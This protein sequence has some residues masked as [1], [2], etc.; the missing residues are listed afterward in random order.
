M[1]RDKLMN[2]LYRAIPA[3]D[4]CLDA[5]LT[6]DRNLANAP[7][8]MLKEILVSY[9]ESRRQEI[10]SGQCQNVDSL[11]LAA[12]LPAMLSAAYAGLAPRLKKIINATG[13]VVH[14]NLGRS[15][16]AKTAQQAVAVAASGYCN[17]ELDLA[18]GTRGSRHSLVEDLIC[19]LSRAEAAMTVNNNAAAVML[20]L[21]EFC[22]GGE[23]IV[24]RG[25]LVEIGGSFR[26]PAIL[27]KS[28]CK[29]HEVG[30][31]NR[32]H[33]Y[34]YANAINEQT[35]AILRVH[36]SNY[37]IVGFHSAV[38]L[39]ELASL[40]RE[41]HLPLI[42]D[43]GSGSLVDFSEWGLT[44]EPTVPSV[45]E[46]GADIVTFSGDKVLGGP[47]AGIIA[48][49][50]DYV[51]KLKK[52]Q[53]ARA[54]R[55]DKLCLAA[56]EATLRLYLD[57]E[58]AIREIPTLA[59]ICRN[60]EELE[61]MARNLQVMIDKELNH[62]CLTY[63]RGDVSRVGGGAFP[64]RDLPT[65]LVCLK[66]LGISANRLKEALLQTDPPVIG[67]LE[68]EFFCLDPRTIPENEWPTLLEALKSAFENCNAR[69]DD[70]D[71]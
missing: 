23:V 31:T 27:E 34:D 51:Q 52:N 38:S 65:T 45:I 9:W 68:D 50:N 58:K 35:R 19:K 39:A 71:I 61:T 57:K 36:T 42:E 54:L 44:N 70:I 16:L 63:L 66:P 7:R 14:T 67:R 22:K 24:S 29:L 15:V 53:L 62:L 56:L 46:S 64:Q 48:G 32:T 1:T 41:K 4:L 3:M 55:C 28:G 11:G 12:C 20:V 6:A 60:P 2:E 18:S 69:H 26:I 37:R 17:L 25:E 30:S 8:P 33:L 21:D 40:A 10:K 43:L 49:R 5:I 59:S 13:V 47:Q